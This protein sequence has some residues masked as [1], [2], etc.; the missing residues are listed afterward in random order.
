MEAIK[1]AIDC[2]VV[3]QYHLILKGVLFS[4]VLY[5]WALRTQAGRGDATECALGSRVLAE[6]AERLQEDGAGR[7]TWKR[8]TWKTHFTCQGGLLFILVSSPLW[9]HF[10][11]MLRSRGWG[12]R[13]EGQWPGVSPRMLALRWQYKPR[14][15]RASVERGQVIFHVNPG[16]C[17]PIPF[18][19]NF[20]KIQRH[21]QTIHLQ[22]WQ[23]I[24]T[25]HLSPRTTL[26]ILLRFFAYMFFPILS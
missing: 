25:V 19:L 4:D 15:A 7:G 22:E 6:R 20:Q 16:V 9:P 24:L 3:K 8:K 2:G 12:E 13:W 17:V 26:Q 21:K 18:P 1:T 23:S 11:G 5:K 14:E 10:H